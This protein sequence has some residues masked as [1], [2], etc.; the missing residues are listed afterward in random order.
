MKNCPIYSF[1]VCF[2]LVMNGSYLQAQQTLKLVHGCYYEESA[3]QAAEKR[4]VKEVTIFT[5]SE[6]DT[7]LSIM[8]EILTAGSI[9]PNT[10]QLKSS[11]VGNAVATETDGVRY[12]LYSREF[13]RTMKTNTESKWAIYSL[14]AH[15][16][17]HHVLGHNFA[18]KDQKKRRDMEI[19]A[20]IFSGRILNTMGSSENDALAAIRTIKDVKTNEFYPPIDSRIE[21]IS[22][23]WLKQQ[24]DWQK[25]G[26]PPSVR[27]L[28]LS[29][30]KNYKHNKATNVKASV[31]PEQMIIT[32]D[33]IP[34]AGDVFCKTYI[35]SP[36]NSRLIP[37]SIQWKDEPGKYGDSK[38]IIWNFAKDGYTKNMVEK[39]EELGIAVFPPEKVPKP[40]PSGAYIGWGGGAVASAAIVG[41]SFKMRSDAM[42]SKEYIKYKTYRNPEDPVWASKSREDAYKDADSKYV[43][44]QYV[45]AGSSAAFAVCSYFLVKKLSQGKQSKIGV[46]YSYHSSSSHTGNNAEPMGMIGF[47]LIF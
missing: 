42:N 45:M 37:R 23:G 36:E 9:S 19:E 3:M 22:S 25:K 29:F 39:P 12:I 21:A 24:E 27:G 17:G 26:G 10:F 6:N 16:I 40:V 13:I 18:E 38:K 2:I 7:A 14:L 11:N 46:L 41:F 31:L 44:S 8:N 1:V 35:V 15:E 28:E 20:D 47:K 5:P 32:Y 34:K 4:K 30:G 33:A 43:Q